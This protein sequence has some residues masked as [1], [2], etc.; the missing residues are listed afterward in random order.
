MKRIAL[1]V[2]RIV[3]GVLF[4]VL[5][6]VG[7][8]L[9]VLQGILFLIAGLTIL[10]TESTVARR[11]LTWLRARLPRHRGRTVAAGDHTNG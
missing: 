8:F 7:L 6:V 5:G 1:R 9:P 11:C 2:G 4:I 3:A 10:S